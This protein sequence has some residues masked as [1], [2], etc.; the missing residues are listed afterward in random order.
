MNRFNKPDILKRIFNGQTLSI[1]IF[2]FVIVIFIIGINAVSG[3]SLT[4]D[5]T[6]LVMRYN[7]DG[8]SGNGN[9]KAYVRTFPADMESVVATEQFYEEVLSENGIPQAA[10][11]KLAV[12]RDE[13]VSNIVRY[14]SATTF[15]LAVEIVDAPH[16]VRLKFSD[17]GVPYDPLSR[18]APDV[19]MPAEKRP[20]GG[21]GIMVVRSLADSVDY[22]RTND[23]NV[24]TVFMSVEHA[25]KA[26]DA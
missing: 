24:L 13:L 22:E 2:V 16:G 23:R 6:L 21:L 20:Q 5:R 17:D 8:A 4:D 11:A 10:Q 18:P 26:V 19:S 1:L 7:G 12:V 14:S 3:S 9:G 15:D 25:V